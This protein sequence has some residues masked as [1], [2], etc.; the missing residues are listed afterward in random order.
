VA[1]SVEAALVEAVS[2]AVTSAVSGVKTADLG[3][4]HMSHSTS[5]QILLSALLVALASCS[6]PFT[7][8]TR[9]S[10]AT[11]A[12]PSDAGAALLAAAQ[13]RDKS[14][15][16][17][18]FGPDGQEVLYT[19]N[20]SQDEA[21]LQ[22]FVDAYTRMNRWQRIKAGGQV[23]Y[24]GADNSVFPVPLGQNSSGRWYFDTAAGKDEIRARRIGKNE[25]TAIAACEALANAQKRYFSQ[26]HERGRASHYADKLVSD[27]GKENGLYWPAAKGRAAS[28]LGG[29]GDFTKAVASNTGDH[30]PLFNGYY[31]R[32]LA[33]PGDF[34]ILAYPAEYRTSGIVTF[35]VGRDGV[36]Y[37]KDLG[38]KTADVA[39]TMTQVNPADG[40]SPAASHTGTASRSQ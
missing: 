3:M 5:N 35:L 10:A 1:A 28:P 12:S 27:P 33:V 39:W 40:W 6:K 34:A 2:A 24:I 30:P 19:G 4:K 16:L 38:E 13:S 15:L 36:V 26:T 18:I 11:F 31:Y 17:A 32:V 14:A 29:L 7:P 8:F 9:N 22:G 23:L 21:N 37:Q 20:S 25:L